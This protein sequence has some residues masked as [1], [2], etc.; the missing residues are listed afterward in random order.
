MKVISLNVNGIRQAA[1]RGFFEWM[2]KQD[3]DV[4]CL[5]DIQAEES[6][7]NDNVFFPAGYNA[8]FFDSLNDPETAGV[9]I[10]SKTMPKAIMTGI[11][12]SECDFEGR[13]IQA[14]FDKVSIASFLAPHGSNHEQELQDNKYAFLEGFKNHL[15]KTRRKRR[16]FI[17][18][19][20]A[21]VARSPIDVSSWFVNQRNSGF[22][23]EERQWVNEI[24]NDHEYI[25][26]FRQIN[27]QDKQYTWWPDYERAWKLDEGG[28]LDY[29]ITTPGLKQAIR[30]GSVY[31]D[32]RFA[33]HAPLIMEYDL[34]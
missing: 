8:Y 4:V 3:A 27:K 21:N 9:A 13:F 15:I 30:A 26:A 17:F 31:K 22:L 28:R 20:T 11:G 7:L 1:D 29:Q 14:D 32:Q 19:G 12:F 18:C 6:S 2:I 10:Y 5:Q 23:P 25:D 34:D 16:E 24:F 33:D